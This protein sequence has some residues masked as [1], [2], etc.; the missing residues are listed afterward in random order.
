MRVAGIKASSD[1]GA[2]SI[3]KVL[4]I[5]GNNVGFV[6]SRARNI[7]TRRFDVVF[8]S[9]SKLR[10]LSTGIFRIIR[11][12]EIKVAVDLI[13]VWRWR[14]HKGSFLLLP[15]TCCEALS[16]VQLRSLWVVGHR[17][18]RVFNPSFTFPM[19]ELRRLRRSLADLRAWN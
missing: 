3:R 4:L 12:F 10:R 19:K 18:N 8:D 16:F 11:V 15:N 7:K 6:R 1:I 5:S 13:P 9:K 2:H 14:V 17:T